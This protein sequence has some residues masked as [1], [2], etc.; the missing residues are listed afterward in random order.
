MKEKEQ[1]NEKR[2]FGGF[3]F[4]SVN[5]LALF[6]F[7]GDDMF[8]VT[9]LCSKKMSPSPRSEV[10][11]KRAPGRRGIVASKTCWSAASKLSTTSRKKQMRSRRTSG[12]PLRRRARCRDA[13]L[14]E[15]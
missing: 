11:A 3:F 8:S 13:W 1:R 2:P 9:H 6:P 12:Q 4:F 14:A 10:P 15:A 5:L 7:P